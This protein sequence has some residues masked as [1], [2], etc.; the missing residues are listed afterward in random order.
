MSESVP[1]ATSTFAY[2]TSRRDSTAS[3]QFYDDEDQEQ[4]LEEFRRSC[5]IAGLR[6]PEMAEVVS[7]R[8]DF[9]SQKMLLKVR[10]QLQAFRNLPWTAV[11]QIKSLLRNGL[12]TTTQ[13]LDGLL[14]EVKESAQ[15]YPDLLGILLRN[16]S[17]ALYSGSHEFADSVEVRKNFR[18]FCGNRLVLQTNDKAAQIAPDGDDL[19]PC[20]HV[21][22]T[23]TRILLEG[24]Y[25]IQ[26]NRILRRYREFC[27]YFLRV[28][29]RDEDR[30]QFRWDREVDGSTLLKQI[31]GETLKNGFEL[32]GRHFEF[33][34]YS[35]SA[36]REHAVWFV[37]PFFH[38]EKG[39]ISAAS[40]RREVGDFS[41]DLVYPAK[42][43][44]RLSLA[45]SATHPS[46]SIRKDQW[47]LV[48]DLGTE[49]YLHTE[50]NTLRLAIRKPAL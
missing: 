38:P 11:F 12:L 46:V 22:F 37:C 13:I 47:K 50:G 9:F 28:D 31:V 49:P 15:S 14:P 30:L 2:R 18:S 23:P 29:F 10:K 19:I 36:L 41:R 20:H 32:A 33:L 5:K 40:I 3:F 26:S 6:M 35:N 1:T 34:A 24:P 42:F 27:D 7:E 17:Q 45:F 21:T 39:H 25:V 48:H 44:A 16:Y 8:H 43:A 4:D